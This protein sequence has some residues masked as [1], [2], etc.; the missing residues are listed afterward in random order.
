MAQESCAAD[1]ALDLLHRRRS[2]SQ[3]IEA[4]YGEELGRTSGVLI[5]GPGGEAHARACGAFRDRPWPSQSVMCHGLNPST[6]RKD[7]QVFPKYK[8]CTACGIAQ[9]PLKLPP[10]SMITPLAQ[11]G[12]WIDFKVFPCD[13]LRPCSDRPI[14]DRPRST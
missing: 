7:G 12:H 5:M 13:A 2:V 14:T 1:M 9:H 6:R 3:T 11:S 8:P 4:R 10:G